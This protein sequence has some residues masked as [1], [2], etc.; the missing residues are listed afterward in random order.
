MPSG[1][2]FLGHV[3]F[4]QESSGGTPV[5]ATDYI[6]ALSEN[7]TDTRDRFET[8]NIVGRMTEPDDEAGI[9]RVAGDIVFQA[10]PVTIGHFLK[11]SLGTQSGTI[12]LSGFLWTNDFT[13]GQTDFDTVFPRQPFTFEINRDVTSAQ[14]YSGVCCS[15]LELSVAPNQ[16]VRCTTSWI[17]VSALN[18][19]KTTPTY[20][21]SP[22][23]GFTFD[24]ASLSVG[25]ATNALFESFTFSID[26][27][28]EGVPTLNNSTFIRTMRRTSAPM[29]RVSGN[30]AFENITEYTNFVSNPQTEQRF[31]CS[32]TRSDSFRMVIDV[33]RV[34]YSA[35]PLGMGGRGR[36]VV[37]FE[38]M[39][40]YHVGSGMA[41]KIGLTTTKSFY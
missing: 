35:F 9:R 1:Y 33:P 8:R 28:F 39:G 12:V 29:I 19:A 34:V 17:G 13:P 2:G 10:H 41:V 26:N 20:P 30:L 14:Q 32:V 40:R 25:G 31:V 22:L 4:A 3:G 27:Q 5:A 6:E 21:G 15:K 7:L 18:I 11:A 24:T 36:Q 16:E 37:T 23:R 38:G